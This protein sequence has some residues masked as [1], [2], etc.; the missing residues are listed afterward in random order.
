L[1]LKNTVKMSQ[2]ILSDILNQIMNA[3]RARKEKI[4]IARTSSLLLRVLEMMKSYGYVDYEL[5]DKELIIIIKDIN[6]CR[7][8]KPR[9]TVGNKVIGKYVKRFLP[10]RNFGYILVSTSKGLMTHQEAQEK[11]I[12]GS[13]I[14]Y[15]Y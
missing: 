4:V 2:D 13:L 12:G 3:K 7:A 15:F 8:I 14:A 9:Y 6:E 1:V 11:E 5:K 10:A